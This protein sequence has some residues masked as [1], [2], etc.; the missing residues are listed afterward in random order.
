MRV[1]VAVTH[2]QF[3]RVTAA[4]LHSVFVCLLF[5]T[6][7]LHPFVFVTRYRTAVTNIWHLWYVCRNI[8]I[9][10]DGGL[11]V[12]YPYFQISEMK[13]NVQQTKLKQKPKQ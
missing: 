5:S 7:K 1:A 10:W 8:S 13:S 4:D 6:E 2:L 11:G 9:F 12:W 3:P